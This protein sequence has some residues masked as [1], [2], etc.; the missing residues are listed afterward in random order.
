MAVGNFLPEMLKGEVNASHNLGG[1]PIGMAAVAAGITKIPWRKT[2]MSWKIG[3]LEIIGAK[4]LQEQSATL[5]AHNPTTIEEAVTQLNKVWNLPLSYGELSFDRKKIYHSGVPSSQLLGYQ[6]L[7]KLD[8]P[9]F[10][11][12]YQGAHQRFWRSDKRAH[13]YLEKAAHLAY[14]GAKTNFIENFLAQWIHGNISQHPIAFTEF[15]TPHLKSPADRIIDHVTTLP[16]ELQKQIRNIFWRKYARHFSL[17]KK[18]YSYNEACDEYKGLYLDNVDS[19]ISL[20]R[21]YSYGSTLRI[22][23]EETGQCI[24][25]AKTDDGIIT[26]WNQGPQNP[27][28]SIEAEKAEKSKFFA[29]QPYSDNAFVTIKKSKGATK[30]IS[31]KIWDWQTG[32]SLYHFQYDNSDEKVEKIK[33]F[34]GAIVLFGSHFLKIW[35][36]EKEQDRFNGKTDDIVQYETIFLDNIMVRH[37]YSYY[38]QEPLIQIIDITRGNQIE[39]KSNMPVPGYT[40]LFKWSDTTFATWD[41]SYGLIIL[42]DITGKCLGQWGGERNNGESGDQ[43][44]DSHPITSISQSKHGPIITLNNGI[45][46]MWHSKKRCFFAIEGD[47][48][49]SLDD[50]IKITNQYLASNWFLTPFQILRS[51]EFRLDLWDKRT[52]R[53]LHTIFHNYHYDENSS[54]SKPRDE[55]MTIYYDGNPSSI[56]T[57]HIGIPLNFFIGI[58]EIPTIEQL[59]RYTK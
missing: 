21:S 11:R 47:D 52:N 42:W 10:K 3:A 5:L 37:T 24:K 15:I 40:R 48:E 17:L 28:F 35:D 12:L 27:Y 18:K 31:I 25:K 19:I 7:Q 4:K 29:I 39:V 46:K 26:I 23:D 34:E 22:W 36:I 1:S 41:S 43:W 2:K 45:K 14:K 56:I 30:N 6:I 50:T 59:M 58:Y 13:E 51:R 8:L 54:I 55:R 57:G 44:Q 33:I 16:H 49:N 38:K 20:S 32:K 9:P 53:R